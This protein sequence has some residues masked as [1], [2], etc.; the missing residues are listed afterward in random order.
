MPAL[1]SAAQLPTTGLLQS[2]HKD[3]VVT[4][5]LQELARA[6]TDLLAV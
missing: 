5:V 1:T 4:S 2:K 6:F 3:I